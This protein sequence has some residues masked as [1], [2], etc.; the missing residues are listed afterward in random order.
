MKMRNAEVEF[1]RS[2]S[3]LRLAATCTKIVR[4]NVKVRQT[5]KLLPLVVLQAQKRL[6]ERPL[7]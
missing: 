6:S 5:A 1:E 7:N 2:Y 4:T 3:Y